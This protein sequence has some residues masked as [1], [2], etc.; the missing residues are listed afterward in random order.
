MRLAR[1]CLTFVIAS[2]LCRVAT[3]P[4]ADFGEDRELLRLADLRSGFCMI[5]QVC[6]PRS[7]S[8]RV[9]RETRTLQSEMK[10][11]DGV[12]VLIS[13]NIHE[14]ESLDRA[15]ELWSTAVR[16]NVEKRQE[17]APIVEAVKNRPADKGR[18]HKP[19]GTW[20]TRPCLT[21]PHRYLSASVAPTYRGIPFDGRAPV[22]GLF[23]TRGSSSRHDPPPRSRS[24]LLC[25][26]RE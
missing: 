20:Q 24:N 22:P 18:R 8:R 25:G 13:G 14:P 11:L 5:R 6:S 26:L 1:A 21:D 23:A 3:S 15:L 17:N 9:A 12:G 7:D 4:E 10:A 19:H 2:T 16:A